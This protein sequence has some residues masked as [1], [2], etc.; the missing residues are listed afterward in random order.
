M[1]V[2]QSPAVPRRNVQLTLMRLK[3][4]G[5]P[6]VR[7][8]IWIAIISLAAHRNAIASDKLTGE[9]AKLNYLLG[10]W[11]CKGYLR[12]TTAVPS[13]TTFEISGHNTIHEHWVSTF[14]GADQDSYFGYNAIEHVYYVA[15]ANN[16]SAAFG[17]SA[18]GM[19]YSET[20]HGIGV[21]TM[22]TFTI[23]SPSSDALKIHSQ[24][25]VNGM[26]TDGWE[27]CSR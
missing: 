3:G 22:H 14:E 18:D 23:E 2:A 11:T 20:T 27:D 7:S 19:R 26:E 5:Y 21:P 4:R 15:R 6:I 24:T 10:K 1:A 25:I 12:D 17:T 8:F 13:V 9:M 16:G